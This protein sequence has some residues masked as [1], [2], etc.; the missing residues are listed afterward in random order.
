MRLTVIRTTVHKEIGLLRVLC[1]VFVDEQCALCSDYAMSVPR[2]NGS[3]DYNNGRCM[4]LS[5]RISRKKMVVCALVAQRQVKV[6]RCCRFRLQFGV[7][8]G[9][10]EQFTREMENAGRS[11]CIKQTNSTRVVACGCSQVLGGGPMVQSS[12]HEKK[13]LWFDVCVRVDSV[14]KKVETRR[15]GKH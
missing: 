10:C 9:H 14:Q 13:L 4:R 7:V 12:V 8:Q 5:G 15:G 2:G 3:Q 1:C 11:F 6:D